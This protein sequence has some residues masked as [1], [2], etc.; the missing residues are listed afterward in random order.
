VIG[1]LEESLPLTGILSDLNDKV[2]GLLQILID[3]EAFEGKVGSTAM[4]RLGPDSPVK[5][6]A[7]VGLGSS[8]GMALEGL[9]RGAATAARLAKRAK[10]ASMAISFPVWNNNQALTAQAL[11]EGIILALNHDTRFKS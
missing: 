3:E 10:S 1:L 6:I 9:R 7:I 5:K 8:D 11:S 2:A 4:T